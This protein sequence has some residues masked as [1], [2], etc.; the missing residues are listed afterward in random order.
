MTNETKQ[1]LRAII[2]ALNVPRDRLGR[3]RGDLA[4]SGDMNAFARKYQI[5]HGGMDSTDQAMMLL[6]YLVGDEVKSILDQ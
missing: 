3:L 1:L 2:K 6:Q 4:A 5:P